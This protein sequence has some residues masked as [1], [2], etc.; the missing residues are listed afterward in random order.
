MILAITRLQSFATVSGL[1]LAVLLTACGSDNLEEPRQSDPQPL[2]YE[3]G[4]VDLLQLIPLAEETRVFVSLN[5][6]TRAREANG[7]EAPMEDAGDEGLGQYMVDLSAAG[8]A[9]GPW[10][11]GFTEYAL[12]QSKPGEYLSFDIGD[13]EQSILA[14]EPPNVLEAATGRIDPRATKRSLAACSECPDPEIHEQLGV[15]FYSWGE[16]FQVDIAKRLQ[17]PAYD[18]IGRGGRIA[19]LDSLVFRTIATES[20]R[21]LI[22]AYLG[23]R[24]SLADDPDLALAARGLDD[25]GVYSALL[26]G[27]VEQYSAQA[28]LFGVLSPE[29]RNQLQ[30]MRAALGLEANDEKGM[31]KYRVLGTGVAKDTEGLL[32]TLVFVYEDED[33]ASRNVQAFK[34]KIA[35]SYSIVSSQPWIEHFPQSEVWNDGRALIAKLRTENPRIWL[36]MVYEQDSL[37]WWDK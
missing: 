17:P 15:E 33:V 3:S 18:H 13:M 23:E 2:T 30:K 26:V 34:E 19:T 7:I 21:S 8:V 9:P 16:D 29:E 25:L 5:D 27:N 4:L 35:K 24:D 32:T 22:E 36:S 6:Y 31:D 14:G 37:L 10:L 28:L 20:M 1:A 11:S 12:V